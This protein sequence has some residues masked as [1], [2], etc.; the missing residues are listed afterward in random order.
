MVKTLSK[1]ITGK[2]LEGRGVMETE[3]NRWVLCND[4]HIAFQFILEGEPAD[5]QANADSGL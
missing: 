4:L 5:I 2:T 1:P 3:E